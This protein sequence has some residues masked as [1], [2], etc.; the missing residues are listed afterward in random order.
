L[1]LPV[2]QDVTEA[3]LRGEPW[4]GA[5][6][7]SASAA[8]Q[9]QEARDATVAQRQEA[10]HEVAAVRPSAVRPLAGPSAYHRDRLRLGLARQRAAR[11]ARAMARQL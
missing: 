5:A 1:V 2:A 9:Q 11:F 4:A 8:V 3:R 10:Q 7:R 6:E